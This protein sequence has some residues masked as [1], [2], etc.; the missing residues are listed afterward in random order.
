MKELKKA[1]PLMSERTSYVKYLGRLKQAIVSD[2]A[3]MKRFVQVKYLPSKGLPSPKTTEEC[4][5]LINDI[6]QW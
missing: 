4:D 3:S 1:S 6:E 2:N 5:E